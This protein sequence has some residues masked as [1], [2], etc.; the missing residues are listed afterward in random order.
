[1]APDG[2]VGLGIGVPILRGQVQLV[3]E[4]RMVYAIWEE[5]RYYYVSDV[6]PVDETTVDFTESAADISAKPWTLVLSLPGALGPVPLLRRRTV[7]RRRAELS[8]FAAAAG[9][10]VD[11]DRTFS[12]Q[13]AAACWKCGTNR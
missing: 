4:E 11:S 10:A 5:P 9:I 13:A 12:C 7:D 1:M 3:V 6:Q 8:R 2:I